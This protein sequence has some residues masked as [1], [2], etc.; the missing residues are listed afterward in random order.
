VLSRDF[1]CCPVMP[2]EPGGVLSVVSSNERVLP[3]G[4]GF[5]ECSGEMAGEMKLFPPGP[6]GPP[7]LFCRLFRRMWFGVQLI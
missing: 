2:G 6:P 7:G 3:R 5:G 1:Q 4:L